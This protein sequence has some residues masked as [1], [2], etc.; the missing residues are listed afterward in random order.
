MNWTPTQQKLIDALADGLPKSPEELHAAIGGYGA[1]KNIWA[2][3]SAIR[4]KLRPRGQDIVCVYQKRKLH[5][6]HVGLLRKA[7]TA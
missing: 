6:L 7:G 5:Y 1:V 3:L 2:H 4:K